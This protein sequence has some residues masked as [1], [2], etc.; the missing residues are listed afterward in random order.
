MRLLPLR[1]VPSLLVKI[2]VVNGM[3]PIVCVGFMFEVT[4]VVL[5]QMR[6]K[7]KYLDSIVA[8]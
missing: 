1:F 7:G 6:E 3:H 8:N 2:N 4:L 5:L